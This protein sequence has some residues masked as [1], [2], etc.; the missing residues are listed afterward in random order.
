MRNIAELVVCFAVVH[1][2]VNLVTSWFVRFHVYSQRTDEPIRTYRP[3]YALCSVDSIGMA[4]T[5]MLLLSRDLEDGEIV[6]CHRFFGVPRGIDNK[7]KFWNYDI[8][9]EEWV[10]E[11]EN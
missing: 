11:N 6:W 8:T 3:K 10:Q 1:Y 4:T 7:G 9:S 2:L 5:M